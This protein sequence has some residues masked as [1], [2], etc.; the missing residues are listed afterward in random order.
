VKSEETFDRRKYT[1]VMTESLVSI[2]RVDA[3]SMLASALD[4]SAGG[5]RFQCV[6]LD[7][8]LGETIRVDL[9]L[10]EQTICVIGELVR[11]TDLDTFTQEVAL[12]F[13]QVDPSAMRLLEAVL[14]EPQ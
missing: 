9:T 6:G 4:L 12:S 14:P 11:V 13:L 10:N 2:A 5:I 8:E 3:P 7:L 1:R